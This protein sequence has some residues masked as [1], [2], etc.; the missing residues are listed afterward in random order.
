MPAQCRQLL[1]WQTSASAALTQLCAISSAD[2]NTNSI[3]GSTVCALQKHNSLVSLRCV[4]SVCQGFC[5]HAGPKT[6]TD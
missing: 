4:H 2:L 5:R 1:S 6:Q 3:E